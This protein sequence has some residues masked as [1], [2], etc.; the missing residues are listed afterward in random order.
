MRDIGGTG[1]ATRRAVARWGALLAGGVA[2][3]GLAACGGPVTSGD[4]VTA[5]SGQI[6][7]LRVHGQG[8]SDGEGYDK[9]VAAFNE[10]YAG[11]YRAV[12]EQNT[13]N[14]YEKQEAAMAAGTAADLHYAHTSNMKYHE[15]A[16]KGIAL[17]LDEFVAKDKAFKITDW[18]P[19]AIDV[20]KS[21]DGKMY[22]LPIRGQVSWQFLFWNRDL[23]KRAGVP[24]P[25]P[26]WTLDDFV[27]NA[28]KLV[29]QGQVADFFP[30]AYSWGSFE[31]AVGHVRRFAGEFFEPGNGAGKKCLMDSAQ[32]VQMVRWFYDHTKSGLF[33]PRTYTTA[34]FG[35]G[36]TA[37]YFAGLAGHRATVENNAKGAFEWMVDIV[38]KGVGGRRG[39]FLSVDMQQ[40]NSSTKSRDGSWELLKWLTNKQSGI[41][42]ALQPVGSLTP[43]YRKDVYCSEELLN[44]PRFPKVAMKANCDNLESTEGF[45]YPANFRLAIP[46]GVNEVV[47]KY[48]NDVA[49]LKQ[50]PTPAYLK[51]MTTEIQRVLDLPRL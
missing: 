28:R 6:V 48:L 15:Y 38:P 49:D 36:K 19:R 35:Q 44:D 21:V 50:E 2:V 45:T 17:V 16:A 20:V 8:T 31:T 18:P 23:L 10:K 12:H 24:E 34:D 14:N 39:G 27:T 47:V 32:A 43:G 37:F 3:T 26:N 40:I 11:K 9:N 5:P 33:A 1:G 7:D 41:N 46:G 29:G 30:V 42:I 13:G 22:G 51:E 4:G 25:T